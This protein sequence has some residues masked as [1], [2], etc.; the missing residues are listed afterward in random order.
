MD[1]MFGLGRGG[2]GDGRENEENR[3]S[4]PLGDGRSTI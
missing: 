4:N 1:Q 3:E 2:T